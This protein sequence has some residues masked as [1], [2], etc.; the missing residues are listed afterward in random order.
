MPSICAGLP[1]ISPKRFA[2]SRTLSVAVPVPELAGA[3][4]MPE[5]DHVPS[6]RPVTSA[7]AGDEEK[8]VLALRAYYTKIDSAV[9]STFSAVAANS[10]SPKGEG[11]PRKR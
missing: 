9:K 2:T 3:A 4:S 7:E 1:K 5:I 11:S 6:T 10:P 8:A